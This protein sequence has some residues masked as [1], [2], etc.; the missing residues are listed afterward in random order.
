MLIGFLPW[1]GAPWGQGSGVLHT[2][3]PD[4]H[5]GAQDGLR[6]HTATCLQPPARGHS[7]WGAMASPGWALPYIPGPQSPRAPAEPGATGA[8][9][10]LGA[11]LHRQAQARP[12][13]WGGNLDS[14]RSP[15]Q[16][17]LCLWAGFCSCLVRGGCRSAGPV[18]TQHPRSLP[19]PSQAPRWRPRAQRGD[20]GF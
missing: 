20:G 7:R 11:R 18:T 15:G 5:P 1:P 3:G 17:N 14:S 12:T 2:L 10:E 8:G 6:P 4:A 9:E 19:S 13:P 16:T